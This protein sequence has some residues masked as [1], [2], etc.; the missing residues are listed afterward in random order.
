M[1]VESH[2]GVAGDLLDAFQDFA[3]QDFAH[4]AL[5][6]SVSVGVTDL[7]QGVSGILTDSPANAFAY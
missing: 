2:P 4:V 3:G 5:A 1:A 7:D 6:H